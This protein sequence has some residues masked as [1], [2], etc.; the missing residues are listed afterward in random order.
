M[1]IAGASKGGGATLKERALT[2]LPA[3]LQRH[4]PAQ[5]KPAGPLRPPPLAFRAGDTAFGAMRLRLFIRHRLI[6]AAVRASDFSF[7]MHLELYWTLIY[8]G[9]LP[10]HL[11]VRRVSG[12]PA[13][14]WGHSGLEACLPLP[15]M[16]GSTL[17]C[18][19]CI[20]QE[21]RVH[22]LLQDSPTP[23]LLN[24]NER[25]G[26]SQLVRHRVVY[27]TACWAAAGRCGPAIM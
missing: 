7:L 2:A 19:F 18:L 23:R 24:L 27:S 16:T 26:Q 15:S 14:R 10:I 12:A 11:S 1:S 21:V 6:G 9:Y 22:C 13:S 25:A 20:L 4:Q 8:S 5:R 17:S 3:R